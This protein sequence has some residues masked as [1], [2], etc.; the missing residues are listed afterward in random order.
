MPGGH[1]WSAGQPSTW[2]D[3]SKMH[4]ACIPNQ[5]FPSTAQDAS[6]MYPVRDSP[7][8]ENASSVLKLLR[9]GQDLSVIAL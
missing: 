6:C 3:A 9:A 1:F 4:S 8:V 2:R 7:I 5:L